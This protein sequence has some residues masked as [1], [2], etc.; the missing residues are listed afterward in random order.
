MNRRILL[1][2]LTTFFCLIGGFISF[3]IA[4]SQVQFASLNYVFFALAALCAGVGLLVHPR[5]DKDAEQGVSALALAGGAVLVWALIS[6]VASGRFASTIMGMSTS[7]IGLGALVC[8]SLIGAY[9]MRARDE[10]LRVLGW[11]APILLLITALYGLIAQPAV[12]ANGVNID[13]A[14]LGFANSSELALFYVLLVPFTL[15]HGFAFFKNE[16][17]DRFARYILVMLTLVSMVWNA[18]RMALIVVVL[19]VLYYLACEVLPQRTQ[20][21]KIVGAAAGVGLIGALLIAI[22]ALSGGFGASFLS[23]RGQLWRMASAEIAQRPLLGYGADGFFGAS[24]TIA[25]PADWF[26]GSALHLTDGTTDPH[27]IFVL[28]TVSFGLVGLALILAFLVLWVRRALFAQATIED[29]LC[30]LQAPQ[31]K[32]KQVVEPEK[33]YFSAPFA[34]GLAALLLLLT[35]PTTV[36]LLPFLALCL[37]SAILAPCESNVLISTSKLTRYTAIAAVSVGIVVAGVTA[38]DALARVS[39]GGVTYLQGPS[40]EKAFQVN[41][42][43]AWDPFMA[44]E[45]NVAYAY[46]EATGTESAREAA[47]MVARNYAMPTLADETNPYYRLMYLNVLYK[48]GRTES[49]LATKKVTSPDTLRLDLLKQAAQE[50]PAQPDIDIELALSAAE[51]QD[52]ELAQEATA[53]VRK[54]GDYAESIW[55]TPLKSLDEYFERTTRSSTQ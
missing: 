55:A 42:F 50:F 34:A 53:R 44:H 28:M 9:A 45:L 40:F 22:T 8:F 36:N 35:M 47:Q 16:K 43:F 1:P 4:Q 41:R 15:M 19:V 3:Y 33:G 26:G 5:D 31:G 2:A 6:S 10:F 14:H 51:A 12:D 27:N 48:L 21:R 23:I 18:M 11:S 52:L 37:G 49:P 29:E 46:S 38:A 7:L 32:K 30:A 24:A 20:R 54:L 25:K 13:A 39:L 17:I